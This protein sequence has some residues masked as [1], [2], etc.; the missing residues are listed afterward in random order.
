[1]SG[2]LTSES[3]WPLP[4][5][6]PRNQVDVGITI[7]MGDSLPIVDGDSTLVDGDDS[8]LVDS[9][10]PVRPSV[11][12]KRPA[13]SSLPATAMKRPSASTASTTSE[14]VYLKVKYKTGAIGIRV[15]GGQQLMQV[16]IP[17]ANE[18]T[19]HEFADKCIDALQAG[20]PIDIVKDWL[21]NEKS[22]FLS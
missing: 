13:S 22:K 18:A 3:F 19:V 21:R 7:S 11:I 1:M 2:R 17:G 9:D 16:H 12:V 20:Q 6:A 4:P 10:P 14:K 5:S 15:R 8:T